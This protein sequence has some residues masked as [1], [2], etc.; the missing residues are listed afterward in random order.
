M[1][2]IAW[3]CLSALADCA[4]AVSGRARRGSLRLVAAR[5]GLHNGAAVGR[6]RVVVVAG[7]QRRRRGGFAGCS[8]RLVAAVFGQVTGVSDAVKLRQSGGGCGPRHA[9][10]GPRC[11]TL[12]S[13]AAV[14]RRRVVVVAGDQRHRRGGHPD[15]AVRTTQRPSGRVTERQ[16]G[17]ERLVAPDAATHRTAPERGPSRLTSGAYRAHDGEADT[18]VGP[19]DSGRG[20]PRVA[21]SAVL[22]GRRALAHVDLD[23]GAAPVSHGPRPDLPP[24]RAPRRRCGVR[25]TLPARGVRGWLVSPAH[26]RCVR[27]VRRGRTHHRTAVAPR[28]CRGPR[29]RGGDRRHAPRLGGARDRRERPDLQARRRRGSPPMAW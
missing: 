19:L 23:R 4:I 26:R 8:L 27:G 14:G 29:G 20:H 2:A 17:L 21:R 5:C 13:G 3:L 9:A 12:H 11:G 7:D 15:G 25:G 22:A 1:A 10:G 24:Q 6:R 18:S 28:Q 16:S